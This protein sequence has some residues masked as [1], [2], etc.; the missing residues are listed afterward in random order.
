MLLES[1]FDHNDKLKSAVNK[2][3]EAEA[4]RMDPIGRDVDG[5][6]YWYHEVRRMF[7]STIIICIFCVE[8]FYQD[9]KYIF[10]LVIF[11]SIF[12]NKNF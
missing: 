12:E 11:L 3:F 7:P 1:Q 2:G 8:K 10:L 6:I 4:L 9:M 5:L